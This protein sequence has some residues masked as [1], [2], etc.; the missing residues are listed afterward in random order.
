MF[1]TMKH[2]KVGISMVQTKEKCFLKQ[3]QL[4]LKID[5]FTP[6]SKFH[7]AAK[8]DWHI[9]THFVVEGHIYVFENNS[10]NHNSSSSN[11]NHNTLE[12][13]NPNSRKTTTAQ[14]MGK[15]YRG[16]ETM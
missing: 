11:S 4:N 16:R 7:A 8:V 5:I 15:C 12:H 1:L 3:L 10:N 14:L 13:T 2:G 6:Y 9:T